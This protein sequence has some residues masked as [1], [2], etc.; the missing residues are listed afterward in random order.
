ME[1]RH[2]PHKVQLWRT[3]CAGLG[4]HGEW[5]TG[6]DCLLGQAPR[7]G[8]GPWVR[9]GSPCMFVPVCA[10]NGDARFNVMSRHRACSGR[11]VTRTRSRRHQAS[12]KKNAL[13]A[14]TTQPV[15]VCTHKASVRHA[16]AK[17]KQP[18]TSPTAEHRITASLSFQ[19]NG[20]HALAKLVAACNVPLVDTSDTPSSLPGSACMGIEI[21]YT[22][23]L[24]SAVSAFTGHLGGSGIQGG[25][26]RGSKNARRI[27]SHASLTDTWR[28]GAG[29]PMP[30]GASGSLGCNGREH[31]GYCNRESGCPVPFGMQH[32]KRVQPSS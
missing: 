2:G 20:Q 21:T 14:A 23:L 15:L 27:E 26:T 8:Y 16:L 17:A 24:Y 9:D 3:W 4:N 25:R 10:H 31:R 11:C 7:V 12:D 18:P 5:R 30:H 6:L 29:G 1:F 19:R 32:S 13:C 28:T 22:T